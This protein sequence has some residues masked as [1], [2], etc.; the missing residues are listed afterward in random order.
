MNALNALTMDTGHC[1]D[2]IATCVAMLLG[3]QYTDQSVTFP[4][5][6]PVGVTNQAY[7]KFKVHVVCSIA[8]QRLSREGSSGVTER[9]A[10][11]LLSYHG[12][13]MTTCGFNELGKPQLTTFS[14][15]P[16]F[17]NSLTTM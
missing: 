12:G 16:L 14:S 7:G 6:Y 1:E 8:W 10:A 11:S 9:I 2:S 13:L 15:R 5:V 4:Q 17:E 3:L